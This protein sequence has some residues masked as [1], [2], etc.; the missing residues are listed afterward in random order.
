M[1]VLANVGRAVALLAASGVCVAAFPVTS[2]EPKADAIVIGTVTTR[3]ETSD[4]VSFDINVERVLKG[5]PNLQWAHV[6]HPWNGRVVSGPPDTTIDV[7]IRGIWFLKGTRSS[8]WDV[9]AVNGPDGMIR[10]FFWPVAAVLPTPYRYPPGSPLL[11]TLVFEMAAGV[12]SEGIA[13]ASMLDTLTSLNTPVARVVRARFLSSPR[14][15]FRSIGLA[16]LLARGEQGALTQLI[17]MWPS[18]AND[19]SHE[20]V[21]SALRDSFRDVSIDSVQQLVEFA[22]A[23]ST[24]PELRSAAVMALASIHTKESLPFLASLLSSSDPEERM[25]GLFGLSSFANG[26]PPQTPENVTSG[27]YLQFKYPSLY[28]T[29]ETIAEFAFRPGPADQESQLVSF[30]LDW[31]NNNKASLTN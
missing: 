2:I 12:E 26:C 11:D 31:W 13:P 21:I 15:A 28:R 1:H 18:I 4:S 14:T 25:R 20:W 30:W 10:S 16:A 22:Q 6:Y 9:L 23:S 8:Q 5:N 24:P 3:S 7:K 29:K 19:P 27:D 17:N